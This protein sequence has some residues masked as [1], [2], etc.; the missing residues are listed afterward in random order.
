MDELLSFGPRG[1]DKE[2]GGRKAALIVHSDGGGQYG[3]LN[4]GTALEFEKNL[5]EHDP[6]R[7]FTHD[8]AHA[9]I[10]TST[11]PSPYIA[12]IL[13]AGLQDARFRTLYID[14]MLQYHQEAFWCG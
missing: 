11:R 14:D 1:I 12:E 7:M 3:S 10:P 2:Q 4:S 9:E 6:A 13:L 5:A 8:N